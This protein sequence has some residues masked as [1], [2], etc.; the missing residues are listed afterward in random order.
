M[1]CV[2]VQQ[3]PA[4]FSCPT[5]RRM[6]SSSYYASLGLEEQRCN[7]ALALLRPLIGYKERKILHVT[8]MASRTVPQRSA[9]LHVRSQANSKPIAAVV[10]SVTWIRGHDRRGYLVADLHCPDLHDLHELLLK[11]GCVPLWRS[12]YP[13]LTLRCGVSRSQYAAEIGEI[14]AELRIRKHH[15][16]LKELEVDT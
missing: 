5:S 2:V 14:N 12:Y 9:L 11:L 6:R 8:A 16:Y 15:I 1:C 13:H 3:A 4:V 7:Q 10:T